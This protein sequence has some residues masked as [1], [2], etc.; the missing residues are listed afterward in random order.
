[1]ELKN[2][3]VVIMGGT[4]GIG[5]AAAKMASDAGAKAIITGRNPEKLNSAL[6]K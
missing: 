1:M 4:S 6:Q 3:K 2:Q 5:L